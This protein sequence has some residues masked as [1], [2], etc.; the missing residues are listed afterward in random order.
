MSKSAKKESQ[1][2]ILPVFFWIF[3][4]AALL[5]LFILVMTLLDR[6]GTLAQIK[7]Q[8]AEWREEREAARREKE[9]GTKTVTYFGPSGIAEYE[10]WL[11]GGMWGDIG[12]EGTV[13]VGS[14]VPGTAQEEHP[15][16]DISVS[17]VNGKESWWPDAK[18]LSGSVTLYAQA[19]TPLY[20]APDAQGKIFGYTA[21]GEAFRLFAVFEDGWY[22]I[23]DGRFYYCS[24]GT[25]Y[26]MTQPENVDFEAVF[27]AR[28]EKKT[29][30]TVKEILQNP[31]LPH[32]CEVTALAM[33]LSYYGCSADKCVL[34]DQWLPKGIWG[35]TD[36]NK[37]FVGNPRKSTS[38]AGCFA[39]VVE[40][41]ANRYLQAEGST[42][43][44]ESRQG[45]SFDELL[46]MLEEAPVLAWTTMELKAPYIAQVWTV[47]GE[48]LYWQNCEHC[49][50]LTGYDLE[51]GIFYGMD[52]LYGVCEYDMRLFFLRFQTM[53]SQVLQ[54]KDSAGR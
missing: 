44:A 43:T 10:S 17:P 20:G 9:A 49:V 21:A 27:A 34:A 38:S 51:K 48:E 5:V 39:P 47:D 11:A 28:E 16:Q 3:F 32:G 41:T 12:T 19:E 42:L 26:T 53:Y 35:S 24:E 1:D 54:I 7:E 33:L 29:V 52:P 50:V 14:N 30:H 25:R 6:N 23:T 18:K 36:F 8:F 40:D 22:V 37:A 13:P 45:V 46:S 4:V 2:G 15:R 31:E